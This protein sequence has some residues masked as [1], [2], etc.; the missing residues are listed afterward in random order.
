MFRYFETLVDPFAPAARTDAPP[1]RLWPFLRDYSRP[2]FRLFAVLA[3]VS[4]LVAVV[5]VWLIAYM[6]RLVDLL[7]AT[8]PEALW[9][10]HGI[11]LA[12][13]ALFLLV[14]RPALHALHVLMLNNTIVPNFGTLVRWRAHGQV[15]RQSVGWFENDFA[16]RI[17]NRVSQTPMA[18]N[19]AI[20]QIFDAIAFSVAYV[21]GA[22]VMLADADP[23]LLVP[24]AVWLALYLLL[25]RW[26]VRNVGP[27]SQASSDARSEVT[28]KIVDAYSNIHSVELFARTED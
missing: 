9:S 19:D 8:G 14:G 26:T 21:A 23:L 7:T 13:V 2:F 20:F 4:V 10:V 24:M 12:G 17:A 18:A 25:V 27:A 5:E 6:G 16:G 28:G 15:L 1:R 3:V 11:E 22:A